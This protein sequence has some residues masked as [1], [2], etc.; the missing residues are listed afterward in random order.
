MKKPGF[1]A[2]AAIKQQRR[3]TIMPNPKMVCSYCSYCLDFSVALVDC[4]MKGCESRLYHV[5]QGEYVDMHDIDLDEAEQNICHNCVDKRWI[6]GKPDKLNKVQHSTVYRTH[7]SEEDKEEVE[8][9]VNLDGG[10]EVSIVHFLNP[11]RTVS[12]S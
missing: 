4:Q 6:G 5:C 12:V 7:K 8:G 10:D 11:C 1:R 9:I 2:T 3:L